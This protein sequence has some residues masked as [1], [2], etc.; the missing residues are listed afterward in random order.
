MKNRTEKESHYSTDEE[1]KPHKKSKIRNKKQTKSNY[2]LMSKIAM[3]IV[4]AHFHKIT[5]GGSYIR[6]LK[7]LCDRNN[8]PYVTFLNTNPDS[9]K[10]LQTLRAIWRLWSESGKREKGKRNSSEV[11]N[12]TDSESEIENLRKEKQYWQVPSMAQL[13]SNQ[14]K[15]RDLS[16]E[17]REEE[18]KT[19]EL[20]SL[21][22]EAAST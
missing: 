18:A 9:R 11:E 10:I 19:Q 13:K 21:Y 1:P 22:A 20:S 5:S 7:E 16:K 17:G 3:V 4:H 6:I 12:N 14:K 8:L 2:D 15:S